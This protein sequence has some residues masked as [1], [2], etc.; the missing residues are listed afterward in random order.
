MSTT[1]TAT[2]PNP[3]YNPIYSQDHENFMFP[4]DDI[5]LIQR[6]ISGEN[7]DLLYNDNLQVEVTGGITQLLGKNKKIIALIKTVN[8]TKCALVRHNSEYWEL[9]NNRLQEH[10]FIP[11]GEADIVGLIAY[12]YY[13]VPKGY[14]LN[15]TEAMALWKIWYPRH[16]HNENKGINLD[17]LILVKNKWSSIRDIY[18]HE[19]TM[20]VNTLFEQI[21]IHYHEQII[22]IS[23]INLPPLESVNLLLS[24]FPDVHPD[25]EYKLTEDTTLIQLSGQEIASPLMQERILAVDN[26]AEKNAQELIEKVEEVEVIAVSEEETLEDFTIMDLTLEEQANNYDH[27]EDDDIFALD[28]IEQTEIQTPLEQ[29]LD[30]A[31]NFD[32]NR[33]EDKSQEKLTEISTF[34]LPIKQKETEP[35]TTNNMDVNSVVKFRNGKL[36]I[37]TAV[38]EIVVEGNNYSFSINEKI[39]A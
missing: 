7:I 9:L 24:Q 35:V 39:R 15:Y 1:M 25:A 23:R 32:V 33:E 29:I 11:L 27:F 16:R 13:E 18:L 21:S 17:I 30:H 12:E 20:F 28:M 37:V 6:F 4:I 22:W 2:I 14:K 10:N 26:N 3:I 5:T 36:Y 38:G 34:E 19:G 31:L 8:K